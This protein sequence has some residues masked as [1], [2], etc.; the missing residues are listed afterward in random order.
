VVPQIL[1]EVEGFDKKAG[2]PILL[3]GATNVPWQLDPAILRPGR[4]DEKVYIPLPDL[5]ARRKMVEI[6]LAN[7]PV[8]ADV[9]FDALAAG[10][11]GYSGAD[12]KYLCDRAATVPFLKSVANGTEGEITAQVLEDAVHDTMKSVTAGDAEAV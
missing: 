10:L 4:F 12:I 8:A 1:Q 5:P 3:M 9:D 2:R 7:R 11:D 6:Y